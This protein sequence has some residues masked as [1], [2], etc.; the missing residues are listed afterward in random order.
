M[1]DNIKAYIQHKAAEL[2]KAQDEKKRQEK[3]MK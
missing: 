1:N 2:K 3:E